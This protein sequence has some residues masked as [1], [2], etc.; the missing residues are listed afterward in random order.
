MRFYQAFDL[1]IFDEID[2]FP[3]KNNPALRRALWQAGRPGCKRVLLSATPDPALA[4]AMAAASEPVV[5]LPARHHRRPLPAPEFRRPA[6]WRACLEILRP[7]GPVL[8]FVPLV[9]QVSEWVD[10]LRA[11]YPD[12]AVAGS[13]SADPERAGRVEALKRGEYAFFVSTMILERGVTVPGVQVMVL[14]ADHRNYDTPTLVQLAGRAGRTAAQPGGRVFFLAGRPSR[15][16]REAVKL[17]ADQND[18]A[19]ELGLLDESAAR[20]AASRAAP[21][22]RL[23]APE[24]P[25]WPPLRAV[26][27]ELW[28]SEETLCLLCGEPAGEAV[29]PDCQSEYFL[30]DL[31][32]C[33]ACGKLL[34]ETGL[35]RSCAAGDGPRELAGAVSLGWYRGAYRD[36]IRLVKYRGHP[37][38]LS[39]LAAYAA[40]CALL[41]L[42]PPDWLVPTPLHDRRL[43]GRGFNQAETLA[44]CLGGALTLPVRPVLRRTRLTA[45]Q[46]GLSRRE[47]LE[48]VQN[49]FAC[50]QPLRGERIWLI[51][52]VLTTGATLNS[53]ARALKT[54]GSGEVY[55]FVLAAG[56]EALIETRRDNPG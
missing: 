32:R 28:Y 39:P 1:I 37:F 20:P 34:E 53:C 22:L 27:R 13:H 52:D 16:M 5:R 3:Y 54:A 6:E 31:P 23:T 14:E 18:L 4:R 50:E 25:W 40:R 45:P 30:R 10:R 36:L 9:A 21:P 48:N 24:W 29:C 41:C 38:V 46:S 19:K 17:I 51:D 55:A 35:C 12:S 26:L 56:R 47:R 49:A 7:A 11:L 15:D 43:R 33:P 42:P 2:A 8:L 44:S